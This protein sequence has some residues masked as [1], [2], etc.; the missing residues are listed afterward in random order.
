MVRNAL[1]MVPMNGMVPNRVRRSPMM[2]QMEPLI[3]EPGLVANRDCSRHVSVFKRFK[4]SLSVAGA[5]FWH[6][7]SVWLRHCDTLRA[8]GKV[9]VMGSVQLWLPESR[10]TQLGTPL[11]AQSGAVTNPVT[12]EK[13]EDSPRK[14]KPKLMKLSRA[15]TTPRKL[16]D[17]RE[18]TRHWRTFVRDV[19]IPDTGVVHRFKE[20]P[21]H[22]PNPEIPGRVTLMQPVE[23]AKAVCAVMANKNTIAAMVQGVP[24]GLKTLLVLGASTGD[25]SR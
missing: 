24:A 21:R 4:R 15:A 10:V 22:V 12:T 13:S 16:V 20:V 17:A 25:A 5:P 19:A 6:R 9:S 8:P 3:A 18:E 11:M 23:A 1:R 14:L 7:R 2:R